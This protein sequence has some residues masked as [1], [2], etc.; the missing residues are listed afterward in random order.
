MNSSTKT[1]KSKNSDNSLRTKWILVGIISISVLLRL[2]LSLYLGNVVEILPGTHDQISYHT[3]ANRFLNGHGFTF[4]ETWWPITAAN[5][6]TAHWSYLYTFYLISV[7]K[8]FGS[9]PLAAR[10]I[11]AIIV[12]IIQPY[13][14]YKMAK[15]IFNENVGLIS[16]AITSLYIY[17][18]YYAATLMTESFYILTILASLYFSMM[19]VKANRIGLTEQVARNSIFLGLSVGSGVLFRQLF[20]LFIPVLFLWVWWSGRKIGQKSLIPSLVASFIVIVAMIL[21]FT[22]Y[23]YSRFDR[24]VL[25][26]TN[27]GYAF[28]WGNHPIYGTHFEPILPPEMG[29]YQALIPK[30]LY[31][32]DEAT[33][34]QELLK[35]GIQFILE[36]PGRYVQLS[37]SRIPP[38][39][40]F[41]PSTES[42]L[43]SNISRVFSFGISWPFMLFGL[44]YA[45]FSNLLKEKFQLETPLM[46]LYSFIVIYVA[47]HIL[48]WTLIRYRL[49]IDAILVIFAA[50]SIFHLWQFFQKKLRSRYIS[51][52]LITR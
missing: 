13:I 3:L 42:G 30:E 4:G 11:Q 9:N 43:L 12:G 25:L 50:L 34:E 29:T 14:V 47:I 39:F 48:T 52:P 26:N 18:I 17:F 23:N 7:Y 16:A 49:P 5:A 28:F 38:Y 44:F 20:L 22:I 40:T 27:A 41:W 31:H 1:D 24:F 36:D 19:L 2:A 6:P 35:R 37:L 8:I 32:L 15:H 45:P 10:V 33:L 21:P 46:L 51:E